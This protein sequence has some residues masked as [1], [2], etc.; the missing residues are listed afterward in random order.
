MNGFHIVR[1][2]LSHPMGQRYRR[3]VLGRY[4]RWQVASRLMGH[5]FAVPFVND[6]TLLVRR[7]MRGAVNNVFFGLNEFEDMAFFL[8]ALRP[9]DR[10]VDVGAN[11]GAFTVLAAGA[12]GARGIALEPGAEAFAALEDHVRLNRLD[13]RV[14][15]FQAAAG[16]EAGELSFTQGLDTLNHVLRPGETASRIVRVPVHRLDDLVPDI[17]DP[18]KAILVKI[19]VEGW[20]QEVLLGAQ[21]LL[22]RTG[23]VA[24]MLEN[25]GNLQLY[26]T[27]EVTLRQYLG[28]MGFREVRY[29]PFTR[30]LRPAQDGDTDRRNV[31]YVRPQELFQERVASAPTYRVLDAPL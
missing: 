22:S 5:R 19:D 20:E 3:R 9:E 23:P 1:Q 24:L 29:D 31:L 21:R 18:V 13:G 11:V 6:T 27:E 14:A 28:Q 12:A 10:F 16:R 7:G 8:H 15:L 25:N 17:D 2:L 30:Q 26:G 4:V